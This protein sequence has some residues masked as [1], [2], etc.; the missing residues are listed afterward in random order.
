MVT[1]T[2]DLF[3][4][5]D[6]ETD[7][8]VLAREPSAHGWDVMSAPA[9]A[10]LTDLERAAA[11]E[12]YGLAKRVLAYLIAVAR[13]D[14]VL[15]AWGRQVN[16]RGLADLIG[17]KRCSMLPKGR[18]RMIVDAFSSRFIV[19][20]ML[21]V[22]RHGSEGVGDQEAAVQAIP[23][24][25]REVA[26]DSS[27][28][29]ALGAV[30]EADGEAPFS[31]DGAEE[32]WDPSSEAVTR[33]VAD[34]RTSEATCAN[35]SRRSM[36]TY[37]ISVAEDD[38]VLPGYCGRANFRRLGGL[39]G[40]SRFSVLPGGTVRP[41]LD[42]FV[43]RFRIRAARYDENGDE[44]PMTTAD[45]V[46]EW[47]ATNPVVPS[48]GPTLIS[49]RGIAEVL[50][51][52]YASIADNAQV[53][54]LTRSAIADQDATLDPVPWRAAD[55]SIEGM[56]RDEA[57]A[58][59]EQLKAIVAGL[60]KL[61]QDWRRANRVDFDYIADLTGV[62]EPN[63]AGDPTYRRWV[64]AQARVKGTL[65]PGLLDYADTVRVFRDWGL[66]QIAG[67]QKAKGLATWANE[68]SNQRANF[69]KLVDAAGLQPEDDV[70]DLFGDGFEDLMAKAVAG[71]KAD[72]ARNVKRGLR[73]WRDLRRMK[74]GAMDLP[75]RFSDA[76]RVLLRLRN[77]TSA[78][79]AEAVGTT[80]STI[81][82]W[83]AGTQSPSRASLDVVRAIG[84]FFDLPPRIL[85]DRLGY[86]SVRS[87]TKTDATAEYR[88]LSWDV[89]QLLPDD[90]AGWLPDVLEGAVAK[91]KPLLTAGTRQGGIVRAAA[92]T[93]HLMR[94]F[95]PTAALSAQLEAFTSYK[96]AKVPHPYLRSRKGRWAS[97]DTEK[98]RMPVVQSFFRFLGQPCAG[99]GAAG[100]GLDSSQ[101]T[102]AWLANVPMVLAFA[103]HQAYRFRDEDWG[104]G[105]R[106]VFYTTREE[107]FV[108][109]C[110]S[111][112][113]PETGWLTQ[114]PQLAATLVP[115]PAPIPQEFTDLLKL[116]ST[117]GAGVALSEEDVA[118]AQR[119]WP[120]FMKRNHDG[121]V[122]ARNFLSTEKQV[123]RD[124]VAPITGIFWSGTPM[125]DLLTCIYRS[126]RCWADAQTARD[127][128]AIDVRNSVMVRIESILSFRP[129]N[130]AGLTFHGDQGQIRKRDGIWEVEV[131]YGNFKNWRNCR[132]FGPITSRRNFHK[133]L[134]DEAGLYDLLDYYF[135][136]VINGFPKGMADRA[137]F[138]TKSG[139]QM[140]AHDWGVVASDF[141]RHHLAWNPVKE[142]GI[143][144][145]ASLNA[146]AFRHIKASDILQNSTAY[147]KV[148]EAAFALQTSEK[149]IV[150][151]YGLLLPNHALASAEETFS[152]ASDVALRRMMLDG[153]PPLPHPASL[154]GP[155]VRSDG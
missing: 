104:E 86:A 149:M 153:R 25:S 32:A 40:I 102:I 27:G 50:R 87:F 8:A 97:D 61:P 94:P 57:L 82:C 16:Y 49:L 5:H 62:R 118:F 148:E 136:D 135:F 68:V 66:D 125:T 99:A 58:R 31:G 19:G 100:M 10:L 34:L 103:G 129:K 150:D 95:D 1:A 93:E 33:L 78:A 37:L 140:K 114:N 84:S 51:V 98:I 151:H 18:G 96:K 42:V 35:A 88:E 38:G 72:S 81:S 113:H 77:I 76:L 138:M 64:M 44:L 9:L 144:G 116:Y 63:M 89:K 119:D 65:L 101:A 71:L 141:G 131:P 54:N 106:G 143:P 3:D 53:A 74:S 45:M 147:N 120:G 26:V 52:P 124:P 29:Q 28:D 85:L 11:E 24:A 126:E 6:I 130:Q 41:M 110:A 145:V 111:M 21:P 4:F 132:L 39:A 56:P 60:P 13:D 73:K 123:S 139:I 48:R 30:V 75:P 154:S 91:V 134:R 137:A 133:V 2:M 121:L 152:L 142:T 15:P 22:E 36:L 79:L 92:S 20:T 112:T 12:R 23:D 128:H 59:I 7:A 69:G 122:Q 17:I 67:E 107:Q 83:S 70:G 108:D 80:Q 14:G 127:S 43:P 117:D 105:K 155:R 115:A 47:L 55:E 146:Y 109:L 90:A 46:R